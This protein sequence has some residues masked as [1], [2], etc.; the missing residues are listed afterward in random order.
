MHR[1]KTCDGDGLVCKEQKGFIKNINGCCEHSTKIN[2]LIADACKQKKK[3][4]IADSTQ[5]H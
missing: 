3:L 5:E 4:Y 1:R 2:Y